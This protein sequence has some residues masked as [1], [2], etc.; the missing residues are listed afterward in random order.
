M[1]KEYKI[2]DYITL[3]LE[4]RFTSQQGIVGSILGWVAKNIYVPFKD[5]QTFIYVNGK[6][7][8][9][10]RFLLLDIPIDKMEVQDN[11]D[12]IDEASETLDHSL[13]FLDGYILNITP[14]TE[15][16]AHCSNLQAWVENDYD[17]RLL[18]SNLAF[19][20][21]KKL[22]EAG[23]PKAKS[24]FKEEIVNRFTSGYKNIMKYLINENYMDYF[25]KEETR[26]IL[27]NMKNKDIQCVCY[28][29]KICGI[30]DNGS[31]DL[32]RKGI[33]SIEKIEG[34][35]DLQNLVELDLSHNRIREIDGIDS[36]VNLENLNL[37]YNY[38]IE[39]KRLGTLTKLEKLNLWFNPIKFNQ[40]NLLFQHPKE[41]V[42][43]C[44]HSKDI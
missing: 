12:S 43:Y 4:N 25:E 28:R 2:N 37:S 10:C 5:I 22:T 21:L 17:T 33:I 8:R 16:W 13:E 35:K 39:L 41:I 36:L 3:K 23:D 31:L 38:I 30:V 1:L 44:K 7:F 27:E 40:I 14:D 26:I 19:P 9:Q 6:K 34:L 20:L 42:N 32:S 24:V 15:F 18:H 29:D 11:I